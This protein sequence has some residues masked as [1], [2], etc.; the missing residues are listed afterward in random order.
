MKRPNERR[1]LTKRGLISAQLR[2]ILSSPSVVLTVRE[3]KRLLGLSDEACERIL[4]RLE[5]SGL[6][7]QVQRGTYVPTPLIAGLA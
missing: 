6:L 5:N 7:R 4:R 2:S 3:A 1:D